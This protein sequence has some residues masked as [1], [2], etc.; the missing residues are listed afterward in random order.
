MANFCSN[1]GAQ[2]KP[3]SRFC[4]SCGAG[5]ET[6]DKIISQWEA[7]ERD[8]EGYTRRRGFLILTRNELIYLSKPGLF[9]K[10]RKS[11]SG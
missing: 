5:L 6:G 10:N 9:S 7:E 1:C 4:P 2:L 11:I 3:G 8:T